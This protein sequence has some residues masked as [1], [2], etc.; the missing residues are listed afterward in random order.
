MGPLH[1][2]SLN[3]G[4]R[5]DPDRGGVVDRTGPCFFFLPMNGEE[6]EGVRNRFERKRQKKRKENVRAVV[7][8]KDGV[9]VI[10]RVEAST[11]S[12]MALGGKPVFQFNSRGT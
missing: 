6:Q 2:G 7:L 12:P 4:G 3:E 11:T 5:V 8:A 1:D 9:N 10:E